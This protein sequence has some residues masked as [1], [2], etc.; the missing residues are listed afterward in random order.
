[1]WLNSRHF[2]MA[3]VRINFFHHQNTQFTPLYHCTSFHSNRS[4]GRWDLRHRLKFS[5]A[6]ILEMAAIL[7]ILKVDCTPLSHPPHPQKVSFGLV[8]GFN[9]WSNYVNPITDVFWNNGGHFENGGHLEIIKD[10]KNCQWQLSIAIRA[11]NY[12]YRSSFIEIEQKMPVYKG[13][14][15]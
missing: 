15:G 9:P 11:Q 14:R 8:E 3:S 1:M 12:H 10:H 6:A 4:R 7:K 13:E 2:K 5:M